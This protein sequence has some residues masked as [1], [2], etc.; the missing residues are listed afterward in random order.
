MTNGKNT[1]GTMRRWI[2]LCLI[3]ELAVSTNAECVFKGQCD[4]YLTVKPCV[5][6]GDDTKP[7]PLNSTRLFNEL[8]KFCSDFVDPEEPLCCDSVSAQ[9][10][11]NQMKTLDAVVGHCPSCYVNIARIFCQSTCSPNQHEFLNVTSWT[12][13]NKTRYGNKA[14]LGL[15]YYISEDYINSAYASCSTVTNPQTGSA[16]TLLCGNFGA[17]YCTPTNLLKFMGSSPFPSP[18]QIN[19]SY[20]A[21]DPFI[22]LN[23]NAT[24]C[25]KSPFNGSSPCQCVDCSSTCPPFPLPPQEC[26]LSIFGIDVWFFTLSLFFSVLVVAYISTLCVYRRRRSLLTALTTA[27]SEYDEI[28]SEMNDGEKADR[29]CVV[30]SAFERLGYVCASRPW[31]VI[32]LGLACVIL[33]SMGNLRFEVVTDPVELWSVS[34]SLAHTQRDYYNKHLGPFYRIEQVIVRNKYGK[35][36]N[37]TDTERNLEHEFGPVFERKFFLDVLHLQQEI[38][39]LKATFKDNKTVVLDDICF[40][41]LG[42]NHKCAI[43]SAAN[44]F[45]N[46]ATHIINGTKYLEH[47]I[48]CVSSATITR[49]FDNVLKIGCLGDFGGP[50]YSYVALGGYN[51]TDALKARSLILTFLV[52]NHV[53]DSDNAQAIA[54]EREFVKFMKRYNHSHMDISFL[55]ESSI[56]DELTRASVS[57]VWTIVISYLFMF[58]YVSFALGRYRTWSTALLDSQ[59]T[60]GIMGILLV[61]VSV[62]ASI[63]I[64]SFFGVS[65]TLIIFEVIPF[66][67][68]AIG[69]DN[70]FILVQ[71]H[72]R[73]TRLDGES[74]EQHMARVLGIVGPSMLLASASECT[75]FFLGALT[76]MPAVKK[77]ALYA[78]L[79]LLID[80]LL[81][82]TVFVAFFTLDVR[83]QE[84]RRLDLFCCVTSKKTSEDNTREQ[85]EDSWLYSFMKCKYAP[86]LKGSKYRN[87]VFVAFIAW[88]FL[89]IAVIHK[90]DIGLDQEISIPEDSYLQQYFLSLKISL[91]IGPPLY[92]VVKDKYDYN[93]PTNQNI[94]GSFPG[95]SGYSLVNQVKQAYLN[96]SITYV[97]APAMSWID[98]YFGWI[99]SCCKNCNGNNSFTKHINDFLSENPDGSCARAGHAAYSTAVELKNTTDGFEILATSFMTY[100]SVLKTSTDYIAAL[101]MSRY[102][103]DRIQEKVRDSYVGNKNDVEVFPYSVFY[104]FY[105]QYLTIWRDTAIHLLLSFLGVL[106]ITLLLTRFRLLPTLA[107]CV[108]ILMIVL[109]VMGIMYFAGIALNAISMVNLVMCVGISVEFCSHVTKAFYSRSEELPVD[110]AV[111]ALTE[112]GSSVLS[113]I[114]MT[115]FA[116]V[117]VLAF[118]KSQLFVVFYFRMYLSIVLV[119]SAH[120][121]IFLPVVL[122]MF[123]PTLKPV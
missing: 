5:S 122:A 108:T 104:V 46:Q 62:A 115:K 10:I 9:N 89:S 51:G 40:K 117:L 67:V 70:I 63:G 102:L 74:V 73:T 91:N 39:A 35:S 20:T 86:L 64:F 37:Y 95:S 52:N 78:G 21:L 18:F 14:V 24:P 17:L 99:T 106:T 93:E 85:F 28:V 101:R 15:T 123:G 49:D 22:P 23:A 59:I 33:F 44:W 58:A 94:I 80:F 36:F 79:A 105:E 97:A 88:F 100:H 120:G 6:E 81:Q 34:T 41:P 53:N 84:A 121:L 4:I 42:G 29:P 109:D 112:V 43:Q 96:A 2:S 69:V 71:T 30:M 12:P 77:F 16:L 107:I 55:S 83:R 50:S 27:T 118:A 87:G 61:F 13:V 26:D 119:G 92:L 45:Q 57:D 98:D 76:D 47:I 68:L 75:C 72:Q 111:G 25:N 116:G 114:T 1:V 54:W 110:R 56:N 3:M 31:L 19:F 65:S 8:R 82:I 60:L 66:L 32:L 7:E 48:D 38:M 11:I 103:T 113:G 90:L